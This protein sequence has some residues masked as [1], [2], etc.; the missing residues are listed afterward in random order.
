MFDKNLLKSFNYRCS[1]R[2]SFTLIVTL[3]FFACEVLF[4]SCSLFS[5]P[6]KKEKLKVMNWNLQTFFD[7]EFDGNEYKEFSN[8]KSGWSRSKYDERLT[9]VAE[10]IKKTDADLVIIEEIEKEAQL[11]DIYNKLAG[12]F[13]FSKLYRFGFFSKTPGS[14][15]GCGILSR[16]PITDC[17][18]HALSVTTQ[19]TSQPSMRPIIKV[20]ICKNKKELT[21]FI[22]H[23]KSKSGGEDESRIWRKYQEAQ[24]ANLMAQSEEKN[25]PVLA[26]GDFNQDISEFSHIQNAE[27]Y[28]IELIGDKNIAVLSPWLLETDFSQSGSY[29]FNSKWEKIDHFFL[30][31]MNL[32]E[33]KVEN[34]GPWADS[35]GRPVRYKIWSNSGY[36]DHLPIS[37]IIEF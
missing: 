10:V 33:F 36:S 1:Q 26:C 8:E 34:E 29:W 31:N 3:C 37:C 22:N 15:I 25:E 5:S 9:K 20:K 30:R 13:D 24:L 4:S 23:W 35:N 19:K 27:K 16:F 28:N 6:N 17:S 21:V 11:H 32:I 2:Q 7:G 18:V 14:S 12:T